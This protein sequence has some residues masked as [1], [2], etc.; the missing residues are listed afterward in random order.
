MCSVELHL[1]GPILVCVLRSTGRKTRHR[2]RRS[3]GLGCRMCHERL[4]NVHSCCNAG[5]E[6]SPVL[7]TVMHWKQPHRPRWASEHQFGW[8]R[9]VSLAG[10]RTLSP[11]FLRQAPTSVVSLVFVVLF[12]GR[13][14]HRTSFWIQVGKHNFSSPPTRYHF[15]DE[16]TGQGLVN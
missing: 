12:V 5:P 7:P 1:R 13:N 8:V 16:C 3:G 14:R 15:F 9:P 10:A 11:S 4:R 6:S 2:R